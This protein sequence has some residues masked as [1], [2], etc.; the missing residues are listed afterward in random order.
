MAEDAGRALSLAIIAC[1]VACVCCGSSAVKSP[2]SGGDAWYEASSPHFIVQTDQ[3][4][5][6]AKELVAGYERLIAFFETVV[7]RANR[8]PEGLTRLMVFGSDAQY[9]KV[10]P[11]N[12]NGFFLR[13]GGA[14]YDPHPTI[15]M[16]HQAG[17]RAIAQLFCHELTHRYVAFH[18]PMAPVWVNEGLATYFEPLRLD[19]DKVLVGLVPNRKIYPSKA[20]AAPE[21]QGWIADTPIG[22]KAL[23]WLPSSDQIRKL[24]RDE[25]YADGIRDPA[26]AQAKAQL[27]YIAA[28]A[29]V[30]S[31]LLGPA[32]QQDRFMRYLNA[33]STP[34]AD[35]WAE[36]FDAASDQ[37][38]EA[39][40]RD[41]VTSS[42]MPNGEL[43][44]P[45]RPA[46]NA[47]V[48]VMNAAEVLWSWAAVRN[49]DKPESRQ[50]AAADVAEAIRL[51]PDWS[52][53][54]L[55][56]SALFEQEKKPAE[57]RQDI[58]LALQRDPKN[59]NALGV[60]A[61]LL[62]DEQLGKPE[63]ERNLDE[64]DAVIKSLRPHAK[65]SEQWLTLSRYA[66]L[67]GRLDEAFQCA[68]I[69]TK[70]S[71]CWGCY[72][73]IADL[74][75]SRNRVGP[76]ARALRVAAALA[77]E[78]AP[79]ALRKQLNEVLASSECQQTPSEC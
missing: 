13:K 68:K 33:L 6:A 5:E 57:Q 3:G 7:F 70:D 51:A 61:K 67:K 48:R 18:F 15:V 44:A 64:L 8:Q 24:S 40:Y 62:L 38:L 35:A 25:F 31:L 58:E 46:E 41:L 20:G 47:A 53:A 27:N 42:T 36:N 1:C 65:T 22:I 30:H 11:P 2:A 19:G 4:P 71:S 14:P 50:G 55:L 66:R 17:N 60:K 75:L 69:A 10:G 52:E 39:R 21:S 32:D 73:Q 59:G 23:R 45:P 79:P 54:Y 74:E 28:W 63:A 49:W 9:R 76:A 26:E 56:R 34:R 29:L 72:W 16:S 77:G 43:P 78:D 37:A 12:T